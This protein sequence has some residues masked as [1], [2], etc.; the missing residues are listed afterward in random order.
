MTTKP[1]VAALGLLLLVSC[2]RQGLYS[3]STP[4]F[5]TPT[6]AS[7]TPTMI[8]T[9]TAIP[10]V[11]QSATP[12]PDE[13]SLKSI[14]DD[15]KWEIS[16]L[17]G[18][19]STIQVTSVDRKTKWVL[20]ETNLPNVS[21]G[22][23]WN[24][25]ISN[26]GNSI[27]FGLGPFQSEDIIANRYP[28]N[29]GLF[30]LDLEN[31]NVVTILKPHTDSSGQVTYG[32]FAL[33]PDESQ[34]IYSWWD[35]PRIVVRN[36]ATPDEQFI[37]L[38][39]NYKIAGPFVWSPNGKFVIFTMWSNVWDYPTD[40]QLARLDMDDKSIHS[41]YADNEENRFFVPIEWVKEDLVY[42]ENRRFEPW[43]INPFTGQLQERISTAP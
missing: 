33:S 12:F 6:I 14:T 39:S 26:D 25:K 16:V 9:Q 22:Q 40:F 32:Y 42:L 13:K 34:L 28:P 19:E 29:Y 43:Q 31:G 37:S 10:I 20:D 5:E 4:V 15:G 3:L 1:F 18:H 23:L 7:N 17:L 11:E 27:Y 2:G 8:S 21:L 41:L 30:Q 36:F 38:P 35:E 24:Y